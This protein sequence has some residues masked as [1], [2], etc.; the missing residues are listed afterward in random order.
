MKKIMLSLVAALA[1]F[2]GI[3]AET[4]ITAT[5]STA[6]SVAS[7]DK[8]IIDGSS[9]AITVSGVISGT[10]AVETKGNVTL[11][12]K[13]TFTGGLTVKKG[14]TK[15]GNA[16]AFGA[17]SKAVVVENDASIDLNGMIDG[18]YTYTISG[19]GDGG[20]GALKNSGGALLV[21]SQTVGI[22][23]N[24]D[25]LIVAD[26]D[27]EVDHSWGLLGRSYAK[28]KINLNGYT[29]RK[30]GKGA[31]RL[32]NTTITGGFVQIEEGSLYVEPTDRE[33]KKKL[34]STIS[35]VKLRMMGDSVLSVPWYLISSGTSTLEIYSE[36]GA[37]SAG[38]VKLDGWR[39][40]KD[41][42][43]GTDGFRWVMA[44]GTLDLT[45]KSQSEL[46][47]FFTK[48]NLTVSANSTI[49][50]ARG[51]TLPMS[52]KKIVMQENPNGTEKLTFT[53]T[54]DTTTTDG[55]D[56]TIV[57]LG[58]QRPDV[59]LCVGANVK[60]KMKLN[61]GELKFDLI[62]PDC[63]TG[64]EDALKAVLDVEGL[65]DYDVTFGAN[66]KVTI[67]KP[68]PSF[69]PAVTTTEGAVVD[70]SDTTENGK[71]LNWEEGAT[72]ITID[73]SDSTVPVTIN[74]GDTEWAFNNI[75]VKGGQTVRFE[76]LITAS[77][78]LSLADNAT[79]VQT[80]AQIAQSVIV[81]KGTTLVLDGS[82]YSTETP[83]KITS[84]I[85]GAG[86]VE[87]YGT[88]VMATAQ[89][90]M[91]DMTAKE[92]SKVSM[93]VQYGYG[94]AG[95]TV[96]VECGACVDLS[97]VKHSGYK[98]VV[99]GLGIKGSG[100]LMNSGDSLPYSTSHIQ[101]LALSDDDI[102]ETV[103]SAEEKHNWGLIY[104][105]GSTYHLTTLDLKGKTLR[106][107]GAGNFW[108]ANA[109]APSGGT[110]VIEEG[111]LSVKEGDGSSK[112]Y[113]SGLTN[114]T[115]VLSA[116]GKF[117]T[118]TN[119]GKLAKIAID[120]T[121]TGAQIV[122]MEY[123]NKDIPLELAGGTLAFASNDKITLTNVSVS[124][125]STIQI[126]KGATLDLTETSLAPDA[127][128]SGD[129]TLTFTATGEDEGTATV[130]FGTSRPRGKLVF[131]T[132]VKV[133]MQ[134]T[135]ED[136][137]ITLD[138]SGLEQDNLFVHGTTGL[139]V[140]VEIKPNDGDG[141]VTITKATPVWTPK[142]GAESQSLSAGVWSTGALPDADAS[143]EIDVQGQNLT[144]DVSGVDVAYNT[145]TV[146]GG[147]KV[148][149]TNGKLKAN[150]F[151]VDIGTTL[152]QMGNL[153]SK[154]VDAALS[155]LVHE[156][157]M[158]ELNA[159]N[160]VAGT[161]IGGDVISGAGKV[162]IYGDVTMS[163]AS[164]FT[165]G[166]TVKL[167]T[168]KLGNKNAFGDFS[169]RVTVESEACIDFNGVRDANYRYTIAGTGVKG[170]GALKN[171]G[172][173]IGASKSQA[174]EIKL[175]ADALIV[176]DSGKNWGLIGRD[177]D[178]TILDLGGH[179]LTKRGEGNFWLSSTSTPSG[180]SKGGTI[181][182]QA[183]TFFPC[184][185]SQKNKNRRIYLNQVRLI[186]EKN[187]K[188]LLDLDQASYSDKT[189]AFAGFSGIEFHA[190]EGGIATCGMKYIDLSIPLTVDASC[191]P[192]EK[193]P[194]VGES[195]ALVTRGD[196]NHGGLDDRTWTVL[197]GGR[198]SASEV[199]STAITATVGELQNFW[200]YDFD[201][202][203]NMTSRVASE[204]GAAT[205]D[206][207][208]LLSDVG[209][210]SFPAG[211]NSLKVVSTVNG[212]KAVGV[213]YTGKNE[214][215]FYP[216]W[217]SIADADDST[218]TASPFA[219]HAFTS[220]VVMRP[221]ESTKKEQTRCI[222]SLGTGSIN[223]GTNEN[224]NGLALV[225]IEKERAF[226]LI[227]WEKG[228]FPKAPD[229]KAPDI[230]HLVKVSQ[231]PDFYKSF[232]FIAVTVTP[233][234]TTLQVDKLEPDTT[235]A[236]PPS[237]IGNFGAL[238]SAYGVR[239]GEHGY[240]IPSYPGDLIAD[241]Q[242]Y[243]TALSAKELAAIRREQTPA[244]GYRVILR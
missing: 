217:K 235:P 182:V 1:G 179:T 151:I 222:W 27:E 185:S 18:N 15:L 53:T 221:Q 49:R 120:E 196:D 229:P 121:A 36:P 201:N 144:I 32:C 138:A 156:N 44:G 68:M 9:E 226:A 112:K 63:T 24:G 93:T 207:R 141:T 203:S 19:T 169:G 76:G 197:G 227:S 20:S 118:N 239:V 87:T 59:P 69:K 177:Y 30:R 183:G 92:G 212:G 75:Y 95:S 98:F 13:N 124:A 191:Y 170:S 155:V 77:G 66:G 34:S 223:E 64:D 115:V 243:D 175:S 45:N 56:E 91:G 58:T 7:G 23:L 123:L 52:G 116:Q 204:G 33:D 190:G 8:L 78:T 80:V 160:V 146:K 165:G 132:G 193:L 46:N 220:T 136:E 187:A 88:V 3:A 199:T 47:D 4:T 99:S 109:V 103:I 130:D 189:K 79:L 62:M 37:S 164:S 174:I 194:A 14:T 117:E 39:Y 17:T 6:L 10:G 237:E 74:L 104:K 42:A 202:G 70:F 90:F 180:D 215:C 192:P 147:G 231:V 28:T 94:P 230:K 126:A 184:A 73:L 125:D 96:N 163:G 21:K 40:I 41:S 102:A 122:G 214:S 57:E 83:M 166:L 241:W 224:G 145:I 153:V 85:S 25:A 97:Q 240:T 161:S 188:L 167:G 213:F 154:T 65:T 2:C 233:N 67:S 168:T 219:T 225:L 101:A 38:G 150:S 159:T 129:E 234:G 54:T 50:I 173:E 133:I 142:A 12:G 200:H 29:L 48:N 236:L 139:R 135:R 100:A 119:P 134:L 162:E 35:D 26:G 242:V 209:G 205:D 114:L 113:E 195:I 60:L 31:F 208:Y 11:S 82:S 158:Y 186:V 84:I 198:F 149:F 106:K 127:A 131:D 152:V 105:S 232:H 143:F 22:N 108:L 211:K 86:A 148:E 71:W 140:E 111:A 61:A 244:I 157:A 72:E 178:E 89:E 5:T 171:S 210:I 206:S 176:V 16:N 172:S 128:A 51:C 110:I 218:K 238:G 216:Y 137:A 107:R 181:R 228:N 81:A 55:T 43:Y